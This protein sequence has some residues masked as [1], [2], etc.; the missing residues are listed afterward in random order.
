M[1]KKLKA[2]SAFSLVELMI[3]LIT[4][5]LI[6]AAFA[7]IITKKL[8]HGAITL[9]TFGGGSAEG[10]TC[11]AQYY[12]ENNECTI[13]PSGYF[14]NG[15]NKIPCMAGTYAM[16][17]QTE[18]KPCEDGYYSLNGA[19]EC[20]ENTA[21]NCKEYSKEEN[22]CSSCLDS[23][24][25]I[26]DGNCVGS[27]PVY[28]YKNPTGADITNSDT[29]VTSDDNYWYIKI[30]SSG[31]LSF[32]TLPTNAVDVFLVGSGSA[33]QTSSGGCGT[34][35][36]GGGNTL[37]EKN[38]II[39]T[40]TTYPIVVGASKATT[41][42]TQANGN[43]TSAFGLYAYGGVYKASHAICAFGEASCTSKYGEVGSS[44]NQQANTGNG[45]ASGKASMS[46][47]VII[48]GNKANPKYIKAGTIPSYKFM[49]TAG[50]D[51]TSENSSLNVNDTYWYLKFTGSGNLIFEKLAS[52][53]IDVF[54]VGSGSA[55]Y[56]SSGGCGTGV[57]GGGSYSISKGISISTN[58]KYPIVVGSGVATTSCSQKAGNASS[59]FGVSAAGGSGKTSHSVCL[60]NEA[61]CTT[62]YGN[63]G[64]DSNQ[65]NNTGNGGTTAKG[66]MSGVVIIRGKL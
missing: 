30:K 57:G 42:C 61:D 59:A 13:C 38:V 41:S 55:G 8:S 63:I 2:L 48:R 19:S 31:T 28:S 25:I 7:P 54:A 23:D 26:I 49:N 33:G 16:Q 17:G 45:G 9:G 43:T 53:K 11:P 47:V 14:C 37:T 34:S 35:V 50:A 66:S 58:Q 65:N 36:G 40:E 15:T 21:L 29:E 3:S 4:V 46:G 22:A 51:A 18:C 39:S 10:K 6:T 56:T 60:F 27:I 52:D 1:F 44:S 32:D 12:F 62:M 24:S 20:I 5:S 64:T